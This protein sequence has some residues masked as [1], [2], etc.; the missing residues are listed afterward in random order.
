M[1]LGLSPF[2]WDPFVGIAWS[3][4]RLW[5][6]LWLHVGSASGN[7]VRNQLLDEWLAHSTCFGP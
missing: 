1:L 7:A 6:V 4:P 3:T 5:N 2:V